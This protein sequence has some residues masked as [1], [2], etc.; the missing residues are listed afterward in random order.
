MGVSMQAWVISGGHEGIGHH[1]HELV[2]DMALDFPFELDTFQ[3]EVVD[4]FITNFFSQ[5]RPLSVLVYYGKLTLFVWT[6]IC[7][8]SSLFGRNFA[9]S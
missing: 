8:I 9:A 7:F 6:S 3:K 4:I 1:F 2:P 5:N